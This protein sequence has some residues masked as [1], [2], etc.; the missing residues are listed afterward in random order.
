MPSSFDLQVS[1]NSTMANIAEVDEEDQ[2]IPKNNEEAKAHIEGFKTEAR[3]DGLANDDDD[4]ERSVVENLSILKPIPKLRRR[5]SSR[6][7]ASVGGE[8]LSGGLIRKTSSSSPY[9][10]MNPT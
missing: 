7:R 10:F 1:V 8:H 5:G 6:R 3:E 9:G 2:E 4:A